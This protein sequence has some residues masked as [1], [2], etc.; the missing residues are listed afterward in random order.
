[1]PIPES[2]ELGNQFRFAFQ[3]IRAVI[4][5]AAAITVPVLEGV[6]FSASGYGV[7]GYDQ[8]SGSRVCLRRGK[9]GRESRV[10]SLVVQY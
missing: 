5:T 6:R 4:D 2:G 8:R 1:M 10:Q 9:G 7:A 3:V